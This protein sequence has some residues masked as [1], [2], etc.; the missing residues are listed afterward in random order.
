MDTYQHNLFFVF[1]VLFVIVIIDPNVGRLLDLVIKST[2]IQIQKIKWILFNDPKNP[3]V[4]YF[5]WRRSLKTA[6][7]LLKEFNKEE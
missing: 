2:G 1:F 4:K 7:E 5:I 6:N 3:I